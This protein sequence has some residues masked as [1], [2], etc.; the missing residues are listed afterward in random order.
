MSNFSKASRAR[1]TIDISIGLAT[2]RA[3]TLVTSYR[4][5]QLRARCGTG[6]GRAPG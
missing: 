5:R 4:R 6:Q 2:N 3:R 1:A